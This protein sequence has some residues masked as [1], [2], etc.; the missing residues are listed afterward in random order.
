MSMF[1]VSI[2]FDFAAIF[3]KSGT[4]G[5]RNPFLQLSHPFIRSLDSEI[6]FELLDLDTLCHVR[7][8]DE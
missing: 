4:D 2:W 1:T 8:F 5:I 7:P 3:A 6:F